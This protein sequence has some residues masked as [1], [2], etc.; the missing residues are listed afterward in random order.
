MSKSDPRRTDE[1]VAVARPQNP[2]QEAV[3]DLLKS[4]AKGMTWGSVLF[5]IACF[6]GLVFLEGTELYQRAPFTLVFVTAVFIL[7]YGFFGYYLLS[8]R[9]KRSKE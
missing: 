2:L 7:L 1:A 8:L 5:A 6:V 3:D 4:I 9:A